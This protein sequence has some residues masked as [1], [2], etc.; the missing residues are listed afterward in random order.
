MRRGG[1]ADLPLHYGHV[2]TWLAERMSKL[3]LAIIESI[4][5]D[6]GSD[7]I[8]SRL[9]DPFWFQSLG[10]VM[11]MD[12]HSKGISSFVEEPHAFIY[13]RNQGRII[14]MTDRGASD[15]RQRLVGL[16]SENPSSVMNEIRRLK[17]PVRHNVTELQQRL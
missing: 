15:A 17:M 8:L 12:W 6:F 7:E 2:P 16:A 1:Y 14:N 3:G 5:A 10:C 9:S 11:G 13:G 4:V